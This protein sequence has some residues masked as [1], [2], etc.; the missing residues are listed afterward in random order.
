MKE[1]RKK[2]FLQDRSR[3][4]LERKY[5]PD[6]TLYLIV[7]KVHEALINRSSDCR[8][9]DTLLCNTSSLLMSYS[10][11][12][13][14]HVSVNA[15]DEAQGHRRR[16]RDFTVMPPTK[17]GKTL[18]KKWKRRKDEKM[19]QNRTLLRGCLLQLFINDVTKEE[20]GG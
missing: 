9:S 12:P 7:Q 17:R 19:G 13:R 16:E 5:N 11:E 8:L 4:L 10:T 20:E 18:G 3:H 15:N 14:T 2:I 1:D 6:F